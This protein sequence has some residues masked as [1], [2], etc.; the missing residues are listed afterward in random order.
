MNSI[1][2]LLIVWCCLLIMW[3]C[4]V[5]AW[6]FFVE[7]GESAKMEAIFAKLETDRIERTMA[8][9]VREV[10]ERMA[11]A[12]QDLETNAIFSHVW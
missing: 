12:L 5:M 9:T 11:A 2:V 8:D 7:S 6:S 1:V 10:M 4:L 3:M